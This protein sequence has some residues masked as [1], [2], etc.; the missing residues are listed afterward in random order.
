MDGRGTRVDRHLTFCASS[1][2]HWTALLMKRCVH[3]TNQKTAEKDYEAS[4]QS[5]EAAD[6]LDQPNSRDQ[7]NNRPRPI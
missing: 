5:V 7:K 4:A 2:G 1:F 3:T 6:D